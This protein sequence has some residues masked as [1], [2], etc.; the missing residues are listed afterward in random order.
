[1]TIDRK[2][3]TAAWKERKNAPGIYAIRCTVSGES[4][5]GQAADLA[6]VQ[7]RHWFALR[8][9]SHS[10]RVMQAAW[11]AHGADAMVFEP[12]ELLPDAESGASQLRDALRRWR[13]ESGAP[14]V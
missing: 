1:M 7:N 8:S 13:D 3:A 6:T 14:A 2:A 11:A 12:L 9:G 4:W 10:N 5:M